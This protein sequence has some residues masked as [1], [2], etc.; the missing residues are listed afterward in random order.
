LKAV[1]DSDDFRHKKVAIVTVDDLRVATMPG[2][3][4]PTLQRE[5]VNLHA[6]SYE[7]IVS[8]SS[9][10]SLASSKIGEKSP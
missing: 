9:T 1:D 7:I 6:I 4:S 8:S 3:N 5:P 2:F 10:S